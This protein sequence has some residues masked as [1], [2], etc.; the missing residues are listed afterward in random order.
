MNTIA[1]NIRKSMDTLL[2]EF[3]AINTQMLKQANAEREEMLALLARMTETRETFAAME[4]VYMEIADEFG[5]FATDCAEFVDKISDAIE[6]PTGLCPS[7]AYEDLQGFCETCGK[8][9]SYSEKAYDT[10]GDGYI[11]CAK[12]AEATETDD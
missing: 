5:S 7:I 8:E 2:A 10:D 6:D 1:N 4:E 12:C 9:I 3:V 11:E